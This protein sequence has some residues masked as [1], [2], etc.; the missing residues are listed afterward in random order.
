MDETVEIPFD[1]HALLRDSRVIP[2]YQALVSTKRQRIVGFEGLSRGWDPE[3][4][5]LIPAPQLFSSAA[6]HRVTRELDQ[7]CRQK[8]FANFGGLLKVD[9]EFILSVNVDAAA[10]IEGR[11]GSGGLEAQ[12]AES[13]LSSRNVVIE[14][15]ESSVKNVGEL[16]RFVGMY[17]DAGYLIALDDVGSGHSNLNRIPLVQPDIIKLDRY[18]IE[19]VDKDYYKQEVVKSL[20]SMAR[21]LG[22]VIIAEGVE[23]EDELLTLMELGV[24]MVQGFCFARPVQ[25]GDM[26]LR[27][28]ELLIRRSGGPYRERQLDNAN[29]KRATM[30]LHQELLLRLLKE[31]SGRAAG[32]YAGLLARNL[33]DQPRVECFYVLDGGGR[34]VTEMLFNHGTKPRRNS[35]LFHPLTVG[36]DHSL[37]DYYYFLH[38]AVHVSKQFVT[39]PYVS[40]NTGNLCVTIA[41]RFEDA[42][43][44][45]FILCFDVQML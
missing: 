27:E 9:P 22:T 23:S 7:L 21:H 38:D 30:A 10:S 31:L 40:M 34:Q 4:R 3:S 41:A 29:R 16:L 5:T 33:K 24:D 1:I 11:D 8:L 45:P 28:T 18:L 19:D 42:A 43:G 25:A 2:H 13:G 17:R 44:D 6:R 14:I 15:L 39:K 20:A 37:R 32:E 35:A 12:V 26:D 36:S